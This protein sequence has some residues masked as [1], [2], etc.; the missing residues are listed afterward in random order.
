MAEVA[1]SRSVP[2]HPDH[3]NL[4]DELKSA[5]RI[6][7]RRA[8]AGEPH[9]VSRVAGLRDLRDL[10]RDSVASEVRRRHA[11][12][13]IARELGFQAWPQVTAA[14]AAEEEA[15][16]GKLLYPK[17]A[18][19]YWNIW[20]ASHDEASE[21]RREHGGWLLAYQRHFFIVEPHFIVH[22]GLDPE[23]PDWEAIGR[24]WARPLDLAARNRLYR[25]LIRRT[26]VLG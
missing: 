17:N 4:I 13:A 5:A 16:Y 23:D 2:A 7:H 12:T 21:I 10:D 20:S 14:L 24:D 11:L 1:R 15:D 19:A 22:L 9:A 3:P 6:L 8:K 18:D 26:G 25:E